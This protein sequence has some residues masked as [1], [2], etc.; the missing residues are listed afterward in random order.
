ML[1]ARSEIES[2]PRCSY[3]LSGHG[4]T[5]ACPECGL[6][7]D[8]RTTLWFVDTSHFAPLGLNST[9]IMVFSVILVAIAVTDYAPLIIAMVAIAPIWLLWR[10]LQ[11]RSGPRE[12]VWPWMLLTTDGVY[13]APGASRRAT[14]F[15]SWTEEREEIRR[16]H[17]DREAFEG[18]CLI[19][20]EFNG[21]T[22][23]SSTVFAHFRDRLADGDRPEG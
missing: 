3:S 19:F 22:K 16:G 13:V 2:C 11:W 7:F 17:S 1:L 21:R 12:A 4:Q 23:E 5:C 6:K 8:E 10:I 14:H 18:L 9:S 20:F 15:M